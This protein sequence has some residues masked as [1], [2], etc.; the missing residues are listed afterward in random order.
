MG[1]AVGVKAMARAKDYATSWGQ[2]GITVWSPD[3]GNPQRGD[4]FL[5]S[6]LRGLLA[7]I[8][9]APTSSKPVQQTT[10]EENEAMKT[11]NSGSHC[12]YYYCPVT[13]P[14]NP[15]QKSAYVA[16]CEDII[17]ALGMTFDEGCEFKSLWRRARARQGFVKAESSAVR[18]AAKALHYAERVFEFESRKAEAMTPSLYD[19]STINEAYNWLATDENGSVYAYAERP[20]IMGD[21]A[22]GW[23]GSGSLYYRGPS[24]PLWRDSLEARP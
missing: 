21:R 4:P 14:R 15:G 23:T 8:R 2:H 5:A 9:Q 3:S 13:H 17:Q 1:K 19:W 7:R 11:E 12:E 16:N 6:R 18:D 20:R 10:N 24:S 22:T